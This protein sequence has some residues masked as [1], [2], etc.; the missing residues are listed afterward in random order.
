MPGPGHGG[1]MGG[2][3]GFYG[4]R[5][6]GNVGMNYYR[7][8]GGNRAAAGGYVDVNSTSI[9]ET[10]TREFLRVKRVYKQSFKRNGLIGGIVAGTRKLTSGQLRYESFIGKCAQFDKQYSER[11]IDEKTCKT[12]KMLAAK[13]YYNYLFKIGYYNEYEYEEKMKDFG[14][15]IDVQYE[16]DARQG[17]TR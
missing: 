10:V 13:K 17:R 15:S 12:R 2:T 9:V 3:R 4:P 7:P 11:R 14:N 6:F 5:R 16:Y 8:G 1:P